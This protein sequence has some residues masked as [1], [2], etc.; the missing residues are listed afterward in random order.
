MYLGKT[1]CLLRWVVD[2]PVQD[3]NKNKKTNIQK[4]F[5]ILFMMSGACAGNCSSPPFHFI[6]SS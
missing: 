3:S 4:H 2:I 1:N 6:S 5:K